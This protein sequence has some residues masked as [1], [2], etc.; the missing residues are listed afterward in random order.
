ME[1]ATPCSPE[2][3]PAAC[4]FSLDLGLMKSKSL[5]ALIPACGKETR[6]ETSSFLRV[7][8]ISTTSFARETS[9]DL[10]MLWRLVPWMGPFVAFQ[11]LFIFRSESSNDWDPRH[12]QSSGDCFGAV[13]MNNLRCW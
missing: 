6:E 1:A 7:E 10:G 4:G 11:I 2:I 8:F 9:V 5:E 13:R 12:C 3:G